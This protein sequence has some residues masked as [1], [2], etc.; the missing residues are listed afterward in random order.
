MFLGDSLE[1][2][3]EQETDR[4]G[5]FVLDLP[6]SSV[7]AVRLEVSRPHFKPAAWEADQAAL[8]QLSQGSSVRVPDLTLER[9]VTARFSFSERMAAIRRKLDEQENLP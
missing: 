5:Q 3:A 1:P 4:A 8:A 6:D 9:Q 2:Y 7:D